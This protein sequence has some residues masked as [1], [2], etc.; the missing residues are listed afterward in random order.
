MKEGK[1]H[2]LCTKMTV[3]PAP[4]CVWVAGGPV[5]YYG[6]NNYYNARIHVLSVSQPFP[7]LYPLVVCL[8][9]YTTLQYLQYTETFCLFHCVHD[10][11]WDSTV[12]WHLNTSMGWGRHSCIV[13]CGSSSIVFRNFVWCHLPYQICGTVVVLWV[14]VI[15]VCS[16]SHPVLKSLLYFFEYYY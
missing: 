13:V 12:A 16:H 10:T 5:S 6:S 2:L 9:L 14:S 7:L 15:S 3:C 4:Y 11:W 1:K 8:P